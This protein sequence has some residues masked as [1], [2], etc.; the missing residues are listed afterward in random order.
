MRHYLYVLACLGILALCIMGCNKKTVVP[1][2]GVYEISYQSGDLKYLGKERL[3]LYPDGHYTQKFTYANGIVKSH[4]GKWQVYHGSH[5]FLLLD[6]YAE[7]VD[8]MSKNSII[9]S[10]MLAS[11]L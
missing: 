1:L 10:R 2:P 9:L 4:S 5:Y 11:V 3:T 8:S 6:D 7:Y